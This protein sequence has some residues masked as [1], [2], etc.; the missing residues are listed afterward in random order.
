[1]VKESRFFPAKSSIRIFFSLLY[2]CHWKSSHIYLPIPGFQVIDR[3][4]TAAILQDYLPATTISSKLNAKLL[5]YFPA[6]ALI[7]T[8]STMKPSFAAIRLY[9]LTLHLKSLCYTAVSRFDK[10]N[11]TLALS[12]SRAADSS[13]RF[14]LL[15]PAPI[16]RK[17]STKAFPLL[18]PPDQKKPDRS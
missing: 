8:N 10:S 2:E 17:P 11:R 13:H 1:M 6:M 3:L 4:E 15:H 16:S 14:P 5:I 12:R 9:N 7:V 18:S